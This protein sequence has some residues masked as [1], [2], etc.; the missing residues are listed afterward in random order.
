MDIDG[1]FNYDALNKFI[2]AASS[3]AWFVANSAVYYGDLGLT[4]EELTRIKTQLSTYRTQILNLSNKVIY[5]YSTDVYENHYMLYMIQIGKMK[6]TLFMRK[7]DHPHLTCYRFKHF[8][9]Y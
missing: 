5:K 2:T 4:D 3:D 1:P 8:N 7:N 9:K 6:R